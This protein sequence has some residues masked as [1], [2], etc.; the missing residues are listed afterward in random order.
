ML[1]FLRKSDKKP[2]FDVKVLRKNDISILI[3]DERWNSLF[4]NTEKSLEIVRCEEK[5]KNLLKRQAALTAEMK[6]LAPD[7]RKNMDRIIELTS[8]VFDKNNEEAKKE[9]HLCEKE[10]KRINERIEEI[11]E[12]LDRMPGLIRETNLELLEHTVNL[13]YFKMRA[14]Q[15]RVEELDRLIE[16]TRTRL[17]EYINE[18]EALVQDDTDIY[19]Y[20][21]DLLGG[22]ELEKLDKQFFRGE[23]TL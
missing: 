18:R 12:E 16:E 23:K 2:K 8:E 20:F 1:K 4:Q 17:K 11:Q 6:T 5:L 19:S 7:K 13:V 22:E 10:I 3:L 9:M 21:H 15:K 14:N